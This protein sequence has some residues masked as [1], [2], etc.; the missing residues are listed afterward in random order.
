[1][2]AQE[3]I[4]K[5][6]DGEHL[7]SEEIKWL[8]SGIVTDEVSES[9]IAAFAMATYIRG[10]NRSERIALTQ[11]MCNSG[12]VLNWDLPGPIIDK[13]STGGVGDCVSL[14]L[15]PALAACGGFV[16][17]ISGRGLGHTGGTL[18]KLESISGYNTRPSIEILKK[19]VETVGCA[20]VGQ[21]EDI[22][23]ADKK[24]Y[25]IRDVTGTVESID[26]ITS[27]ILSKKLAAGLNALVLD[28]KCGNGAFMSSK[29]KAEALSVALTDVGSGLGCSTR[30]VLTD[31]NQPLCSSVGNS[32]EVL[33]VINLLK[34]DAKEERL[35]EV[36]CSLGGNLLALSG[37]ANS[38]E[39]GSAQVRRKI[40]NGES[41]SIFEQMVFSLGGKANFLSRVNYDL[42]KA[43]IIEDLYSFSTGYVNAIDT[44]AIGMTILVLGGA[45]RRSDDNIDYA[46]GLENVIKVQDWVN[47]KVPLARIHA[48]DQRSLDLVKSVLPNAFSIS[49]EILNDQRS[50]IIEQ[51]D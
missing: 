21:T 22:A 32:L 16:P 3:I 44:R 40:E 11:A 8:I 38:V 37:L 41:A 24:L 17:M 26:L 51:S 49:P 9:Q 34:G 33:K 42:P 13:H 48:R 36:V 29:K 23:P 27:S 35:M 6:R 28:I 19:T 12:T 20:I 50:A 18:D 31:M 15:A 5:K 47:P 30:A 46:V 14:L 25:A 2:F 10:M 4:R 1:M 43:P 45:R 7:K 39:Q